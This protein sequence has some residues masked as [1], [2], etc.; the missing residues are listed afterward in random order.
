M[1]AITASG[2]VAAFAA[3]GLGAGE[4]RHFQSASAALHYTAG[5][6]TRQNL[7]ELLRSAL[8]FESG[9]SQNRAGNGLK[10]YYEE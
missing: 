3:L 7:R 6:S 5:E 9:I 1:V 4:S 2:K 8:R 10:F